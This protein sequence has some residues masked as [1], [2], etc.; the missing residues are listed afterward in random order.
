V[1]AWQVGMGGRA[2][3]RANVALGNGQRMVERVKT[4]LRDALSS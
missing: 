1:R 3:N 4:R 2:I